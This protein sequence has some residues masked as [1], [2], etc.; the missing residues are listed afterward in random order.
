ME[1]FFGEIYWGDQTNFT[2]GFVRQ[3]EVRKLSNIDSMRNFHYGIRQI[4]YELLVELL[5]KLKLSDLIDFNDFVK[6]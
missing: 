4:I 3:D 2:H 6:Y 1:E 5:E